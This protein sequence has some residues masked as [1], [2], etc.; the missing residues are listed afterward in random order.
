MQFFAGFFRILHH[1]PDLRLFDGIRKH[2]GQHHTHRICT[3]CSQ[4][5]CR[6]V[7]AVMPQIFCG[8]RDRI[9]GHH[10]NFILAHL[11]GS[12]VLSDRRTN[13]D[14]LSSVFYLF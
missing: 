2:Y 4:I 5:I 12:A 6:D 11:K 3:G 1:F 10:Q 13:Q 8:S 9:C 14:F 7:D